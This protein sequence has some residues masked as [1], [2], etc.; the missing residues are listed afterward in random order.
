MTGS[1]PRVQQSEG[2]G[3]TC[4]ARPW[5]GRTELGGAAG[6]VARSAGAGSCKGVTALGDMDSDTKDHS[7]C[8]LP[9][10][11][12]ELSAKICIFPVFFD[13]LISPRTKTFLSG[14]PPQAGSAS[15]F[16]CPAQNHLLTSSPWLPF[17][18]IPPYHFPGLLA[19]FL[20]RL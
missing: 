16:D 12:S 18:Q 14:M 9:L 10:Y 3:K 15:S 19:L 8:L 11:F 1:G 7:Q 2:A 13:H 6:G 4:T 5:G 17:K 20:H